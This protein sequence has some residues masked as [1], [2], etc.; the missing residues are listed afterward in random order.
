[1]DVSAAFRAD[2]QCTVLLSSREVQHIYEQKWRGSTGLAPKS[3]WFTWL[4]GRML[5][6]PHCI[7]LA[8]YPPLDVRR[9]VSA[10]L[11]RHLMPPPRVK[12]AIHSFFDLALAVLL[13]VVRA[14]PSP[15][16]AVAM[17]H[18]TPPPS[19]HAT[20]ASSSWDGA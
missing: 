15:A 12:F 13:V 19:A 7:I 2:G 9:Y 20:A 8:A 3:D 17:R 11:Y 6:W 18:H 5:M 10:N 4:L 14:L 1:V 16:T